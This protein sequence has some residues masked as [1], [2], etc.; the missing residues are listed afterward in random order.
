MIHKKFIFFVPAMARY[1][2]EEFLNATQERI[3][4]SPRQG[5]LADYDCIYITEAQ[6]YALSPD[7]CETLASLIKNLDYCPMVIG[8]VVPGG[9]FEWV[10]E[11]CKTHAGLFHQAKGGDVYPADKKER[12]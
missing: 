2:F 6:G 7:I 9:Y 3:N 10:K 5:I 11:H 4:G 1:L 8:T 12:E